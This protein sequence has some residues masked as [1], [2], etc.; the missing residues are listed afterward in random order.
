MTRP[1]LFYGICSAVLLVAAI[2]VLV[3]WGLTGHELHGLSGP[4]GL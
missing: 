2:A 4:D 3:S 1:G